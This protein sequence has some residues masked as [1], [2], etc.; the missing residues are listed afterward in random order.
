M[1]P[2]SSPDPLPFMSILKAV[3]HELGTPRAQRSLVALAAAVSLWFAPDFMRYQMSL[4]TSPDWVR[5]LNEFL[6]WPT[7]GFAVLSLLVA[8]LQWVLFKP[9]SLQKLRDFKPHGIAD[10]DHL[11][12]LLYSIS[13]RRLKAAEALL[14]R[15]T[16]QGPLR[17]GHLVWV[18]D[19]LQGSAPDSVV[20]N[21][22]PRED[23]PYD[24]DGDIA[25]SACLKF[26]L[27]RG[28]TTVRRKLYDHL[29]AYAERGSLMSMAL[30]G[31]TLLSGKG[32]PDLA[33]DPERGLAWLKRC[34]QAP[35][36][37]W[38]V[39]WLLADLAERSG[40]SEVAFD[41]HQRATHLRVAKGRPMPSGHVTAMHSI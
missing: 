4:S 26:M 31:E 9:A 41:L 16:S 30:V 3:R 21:F 29:L 27:E 23:Q 11:S 25:V 39:V 35:N 22:D 5:E 6:F 7:R 2:T 28:D 8:V 15:I 1:N 24:I 19:V 34:A 38:H 14:N 17:T 32:V 10:P 20:P 37:P 33:A 13:P 12:L 36:P 18:L 40:D